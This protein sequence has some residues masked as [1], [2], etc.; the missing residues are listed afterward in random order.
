MNGDRCA[1][2]MLTHTIQIREAAVSDLAAINEIIDAAIMTW[3]L[4]ERVKR[5]SLPSYHYKEHDLQTIELIA[6]K[7]SEHNVIG[8]AAWEQA[9]PKD[10]PEGF[11]ALLLHGIYVNPE[12]H[13][14]GIGSQLLHAAEQAA[15][16]QG[17]DGLLVKAQA[18]AAKFFLAQGMQPLEVKD[19]R[20]EYMHRFWNLL[21]QQEIN[22]EKHE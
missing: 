15:I 5:L 3:D 21:K 13:H 9:D 19:V 16:K 6:A 1:N 11:S 4:P 8:V 20:R 17:Y 2:Y 7:D 22:K 14:Q 18:D 12:Q 10:T